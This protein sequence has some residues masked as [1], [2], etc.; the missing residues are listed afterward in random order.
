[1]SRIMHY[2]GDDTADFYICRDERAEAEHQAKFYLE[3]D[4]GTG[5]F[6]TSRIQRFETVDQAQHFC[7]E[8]IKKRD[9]TDIMRK[10]LDAEAEHRNAIKEEGR[11][12]FN[13]FM[14]KI[15]GLGVSPKDV[16]SLI[17][18]FNDLGDYA[19]LMLV[20]PNCM[21][22]YAVAHP[23]SEISQDMH[24]TLGEYM[25][26]FQT[27]ID[28]CVVDKDTGEHV[29]P[30]ICHLSPDEVRSGEVAYS[31]SEEWLRSLPL[32]N[33]NND[34]GTPL[35]VVKT[36]LTRDQTHF[37]LGDDD[38]IGFDDPAMSMLF[39]RAD[40]AEATFAQRLDYL[41]NGTPFDVPFDG[42]C[43]DVEDP[44]LRAE[45]CRFLADHDTVN[46]INPHCSGV[47]MLAYSM[48]QQAGNLT[49]FE[50][51]NVSLTRTEP[52]KGL[53]STID[54]KVFSAEHAAKQARGESTVKDKAQGAGKEL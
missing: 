30:A 20:N 13:K 11:A 23:Q 8:L 22:Y 47:R 19:R 38:T 44:R 53:F 18:A 12:E 52:G 36:D 41:K 51:C 48:V 42:N 5:T 3:F 7:D 27:D 21:H 17:N 9:L 25:D 4:I 1:M 40:F 6:N 10:A 49:G 54:G 26:T 43:M 32:C 15:T 33:V 14:D 35:A 16:P 50:F 34:N 31:P 24:M 37:L 29:C 45:L 28:V 2:L 39:D 46:I